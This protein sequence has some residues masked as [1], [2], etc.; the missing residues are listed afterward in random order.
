M[1]K[2]LLDNLRLDKEKIEKEIDEANAAVR[3]AAEKTPTLFET[4]AAT[5]LVRVSD[6]VTLQ[7]ASSKPGYGTQQTDSHN[8]H[9][10]SAAINEE[11]EV[12]VKHTTDI[13]NIFSL[14]KYLMNMLSKADNLNSIQNGKFTSDKQIKNLKSIQKK[15][16]G[17]RQLDEVCSTGIQLLQELQN[18]AEGAHGAVDESLREEAA[19]FFRNADQLLSLIHI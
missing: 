15:V 5:V 6:L 7:F 19:E 2:Q 3:K 17:S 18:V 10:Q 13:G 11:L 4:V 1:S 8:E 12:L 16:K 14:G 9:P